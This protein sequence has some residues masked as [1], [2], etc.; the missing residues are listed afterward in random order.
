VLIADGVL[1]A[2]AAADIEGDNTLCMPTEIILDDPI[3]PFN[4][5]TQR[6][7]FEMRRSEIRMAAF[8]FTTSLIS[9]DAL[10]IPC[11]SQTS[12][13]GPQEA[14][15]PSCQTAFRGRWR[16]AHSQVQEV[17]GEE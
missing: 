8:L 15:I 16:R 12:I 9:S 4:G 1:I 10:E 3:N 7:A 17:R 11:R 13:D 5:W 6:T 2:D 14:V